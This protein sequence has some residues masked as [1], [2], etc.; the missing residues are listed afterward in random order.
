MHSESVVQVWVT[1]VQSSPARRV[2][3]RLQMRDTESHVE[4]LTHSEAR[5][6]SPSSFGREHTPAEHMPGAWHWPVNAQVA[7]TNFLARHTAAS[8]YPLT[9][10]CAELLH[11]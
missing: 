9:P 8:Q 7:P 3:V 4:G 11:D 1:P 10:H 2:L 6:G 5:H